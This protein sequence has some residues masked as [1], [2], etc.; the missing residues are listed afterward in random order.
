MHN[1]DYCM[2][3]I[4]AFVRTHLT[5]CCGP[6]GCC[7]R[8]NVPFT[9]PY[10]DMFSI[11]VMGIKNGTCYYKIINVHK[12]FHSFVLCSKSGNLVFPC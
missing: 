11:S 10:Q 7:A 8:E 12:L 6:I 3:I 1:I 2:H 5:N 4:L 9:E